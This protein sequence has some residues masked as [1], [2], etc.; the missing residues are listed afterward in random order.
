MRTSSKAGLL[1]GATALIAARSARTA[2]RAGPP[3]PAPVR[4]TVDPATLP[5]PKLFAPPRPGEQPKAFRGMEEESAPE[6]PSRKPAW[7]AVALMIVGV[8]LV[9][10]CVATTQL[11]LLPIGL[12]VGA[13]GMTIAWRAKIMDDVSVSDSPDGHG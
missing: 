12:V 4:P 9:A 10:L 3:R 13:I 7:F 11:L 1:A 2:R 6:V 5:H 8:I